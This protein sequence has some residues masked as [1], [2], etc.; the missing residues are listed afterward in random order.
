[1]VPVR[2]SARSLSSLRN[3]ATVTSCIYPALPASTSTLKLAR[4]TLPVAAQELGSAEPGCGWSSLSTAPRSLRK[5]RLG[6][7]MRMPVSVESGSRR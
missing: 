3:A 7:L 1:M 5:R 2:I 4:N 6:A